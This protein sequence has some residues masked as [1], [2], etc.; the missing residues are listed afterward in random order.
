MSDALP[1]IKVT[2]SPRTLIDSVAG[3][4][5]EVST[6][7][8][9]Y[10]ELKSKYKVSNVVREDGRVRVKVLNDG[11]PANIDAK[12]LDP[13]LEDAYLWNVGHAGV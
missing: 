6:S 7:E 12:P 9:G 11:A 1:K 10:H 5:F 2:D 13:T 4:V 8:D 3:K